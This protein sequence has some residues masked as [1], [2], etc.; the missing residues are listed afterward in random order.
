MRKILT[1]AAAVGNAAGRVLNWRPR[2]SLGWSYYP[3]LI[4]DQHVVAGW[5]QFRDAAPHA[6]QGRLLQTVAA[7][8]CTH[9]GLIGFLTGTKIT[10]TAAKRT[11]LRC[12]RLGVRFKGGGVVSQQFDYNVSVS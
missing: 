2:E 5:R 1:D 6:D 10:S 9:P 8:R 4:L 7:D 11:R 12:R 3:R